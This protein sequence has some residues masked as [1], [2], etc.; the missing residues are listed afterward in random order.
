[1]VILLNLG[2]R[3]QQCLSRV[4]MN[5]PLNMD[6][7]IVGEMAAEMAIRLKLALTGWRT[8]TA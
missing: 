6:P 2:A 7:D 8:S 1:M 5:N 3:D 4:N